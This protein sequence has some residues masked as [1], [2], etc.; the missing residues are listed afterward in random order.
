M[1]RGARSEAEADTYRE[2]DVS[3]PLLVHAHNFNHDTDSEASV[4]EEQ[5]E[6][7]SRWESSFINTY[8]DKMYQAAVR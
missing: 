5:D 6:G 7:I 1:E 8:L 4:A 3:L 2:E